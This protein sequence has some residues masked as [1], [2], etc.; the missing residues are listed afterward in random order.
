MRSDSYE[1][2]N[3]SHWIQ[4]ANSPDF[5]PIFPGDTRITMLWVPPIQKEIPKPLLMKALEDEAPSFMWTLLHT[6]LPPSR[7]RLRIPIVNTSFKDDASQC[8]KSHLDL[9]I[10]DHCLFDSQGRITWAEFYAKFKDFLPPGEEMSKNKLGRLITQHDR[11]KSAS[12]TN[13][14]RMIEGITWK[15]GKD[16]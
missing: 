15:G 6:T 12:G 7:G 11:I 10:E 4:C 9:F 2:P 13:N 1:V 16:K 5:C 14:T 3:T 8:N